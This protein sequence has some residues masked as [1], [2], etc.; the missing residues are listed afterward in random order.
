MDSA[1][2]GGEL[3]GFEQHPLSAVFPSMPAK[4]FAELRADIAKNGLRVPV[5]SFRAN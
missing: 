1:N 2:W 3:A 5:T 4:E